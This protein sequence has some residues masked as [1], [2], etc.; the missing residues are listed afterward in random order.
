MRAKWVTDGAKRAGQVRLLAADCKQG[1]L[2]E[3]ECKDRQRR[4]QLEQEG[5]STREDQ[6]FGEGEIGEASWMTEERA[7][8]GNYILDLA[9]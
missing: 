7:V 4:C 8:I 3:E 9:A 5:E 1:Q 2:V 6:H